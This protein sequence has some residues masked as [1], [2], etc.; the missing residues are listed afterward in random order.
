[1]NYIKICQSIT[2][3]RNK[4][5]GH[6]WHSCW[7]IGMEGNFQKKEEIFSSTSNTIYN[8]NNLNNT[9]NEKNNN[10]KNIIMTKHRLDKNIKSRIK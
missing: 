4:K 7:K 10:N 8:N 9:N 1:M 6:I 3:H 5:I 2:I